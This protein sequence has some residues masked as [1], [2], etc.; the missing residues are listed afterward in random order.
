MPAPT[1][2]VQGTNG[3]NWLDPPFS[4]WAVWHLDDFATH[5]TVTRGQ[6]PA[7]ELPRREPEFDLGAVPLPFGLADGDQPTVDELLAQTET[8]AFVVVHDG[9]LVAEHY[10]H[11]G[12]EDERHSVLSITKSLVG[13]VAGI[14]IDGGHLD[15]AR[16]VASYVEE[17]AG[18]G[19]AD[20]TVRD[21]LDMRSGVRFVEDYNDPDSD[22]SRLDHH[23]GEGGIRDYLGGLV[24]ERPHGGAFRYR[25]SETDVLGWVCEQA[26]GRPMAAL[27]STHLWSRIGTEHDAFITCDATGMAVHDGGFGATARDLA[28]FGMMLLDGGAVPTQDGGKEQI[29]PAR[30]LRQAWGVDA[31]IRSAYVDS[32]A[33]VTSPGGWYRNQ[34][35]M[36]PGANGDVLLCLGIHGQLIHVSRRTR[37]V[38]VKL[39]HWPTP[40]DHRR[41]H[42]TLRMCDELGAHLAARG[43]PLGERSGPGARGVTAGPHSGLRVNRPVTAPSQPPVTTP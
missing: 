36:R 6:G 34:F 35:W 26:S 23:L 38:C 43:R 24:Q 7:R 2:R 11:D 22:I 13:C 29:V 12:A 15:P 4:A 8:D 27:I 9:A 14:L 39:S 42:A 21:L 19:Y 3:D 40:T 5:A 28:R 31:D 30:W 20:A 32:P 18:T 33:E 37:T 10:S 1:A 17:L 25:S 16:P 41:S